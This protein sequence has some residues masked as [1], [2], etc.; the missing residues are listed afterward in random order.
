[1]VFPGRRT[2]RAAGA[3][4]PARAL[5]E[6]ERGWEAGDAL[7]PG[8]G[9]GGFSSSRELKFPRRLPAAGRVLDSSAALQDAA[10]SDCQ[11]LLC[12]ARSVASAKAVLYFLKNPFIY[13]FIYLPSYLPIYLPTCSWAPHH[14]PRPC[15]RASL[16]L[17]LLGNP[18]VGFLNGV[19]SRFSHH[20]TSG[21]SRHLPAAIPCHRA[22]S[23]AWQATVVKGLSSEF[24]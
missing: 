11:P 1:M 9:L 18:R 3:G 19:A 17:P 15:F 7:R 10:E 16:G 23:S 8:C 14:R 20:W 22:P 2:A 13:L 24:L 5:P 12:Q 6:L 4:A 21:T